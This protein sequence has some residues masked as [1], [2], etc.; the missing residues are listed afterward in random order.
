MIEEVKQAAHV[1]ALKISWRINRS[2]IFIVVVMGSHLAVAAQSAVEEEIVAFARAG[3]PLQPAS[4]GKGSYLLGS[5]A[6]GKV[7]EVR[8]RIEPKLKDWRAFWNKEVCSDVSTRR[9][10]AMGGTVA[11]QA[12]GTDNK[13]LGGLIIKPPV[14]A[15]LG[16]PIK[17][18]DATPASTLPPAPTPLRTR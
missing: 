15:A 10:L 18:A 9:I 4:N 8:L 14:C 17:T 3:S 1:A 11:I 2:V 13:L 6:K 16:V 12:E 5:Q 7:L